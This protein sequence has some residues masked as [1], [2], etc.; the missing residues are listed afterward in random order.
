M[1]PLLSHPMDYRERR[2]YNGNGKITTQ[3]I[4]QCGMAPFM[5]LNLEAVNTLGVW[6]LQVDQINVS[7]SPWA[8]KST[9]RGGY[10][11]IHYG[12]FTLHLKP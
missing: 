9:W 2:I 1:S 7:L 8:T 12:G 10:G 11:L 3:V 6:S 5:Y 4:S